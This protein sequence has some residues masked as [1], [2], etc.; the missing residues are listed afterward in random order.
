MLEKDI[1][2][3]KVYKTVEDYKEEMCKLHPQFE[4]EVMKKILETFFT[5]MHY[6]LTRRFLNVGYHNKVLKFGFIIIQGSYSLNV[7][8]KKLKTYQWQKRMQWE[9]TNYLKG[10]TKTKINTVN[11]LVKKGLTVDEIQKKTNY[12]IKVIN[13]IINEP[14]KCI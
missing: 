10:V 2:N 11:A 4:W 7:V 3:V 8:Y 1:S 14:K 6:V 9:N 13:K 5:S 12:S